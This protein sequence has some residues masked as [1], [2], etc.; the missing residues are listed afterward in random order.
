MFSRTPRSTPATPAWCRATRSRRTTSTSTCRATSTRPRGR[1]HP[2]HRRPPPRRHPHAG[3]RCARRLLAGDPRR[4]RCA[5]TLFKPKPAAPA[6]RASGPG[7]E[8]KAR[9]STATRVRRLHRGSGDPL[10]RVAQAP[11]PPVFGRA[12]GKDCHPKEVIRELAED[13]LATRRAG[14]A[15]RSLRHLPAPDGLLG[16]D[17][18][19]R[20][21]PHRR[22]R[23]GG[24][25]HAH[26]GDR[27]EGQD[28][29]QGL[30]LRP[31]PAKSLIVARYFAEGAGGH[32]GATGQAGSRS[33]ASLAELEEEHGGEEGAISELEKVNRA[34]VVARLKEIKGDK[35]IA[36]DES[37][38]CCGAEVAEACTNDEADLKREVKAAQEA[39]LDQL[40]VRAV[41]EAERG[42]D[43]DPGGGRQVAGHAL[44]PPC[45]ASWIAS[46]RR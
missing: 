1:G 2:G 44:P 11:P 24:Q 12:F 29:G 30:D 3:H 7:D 42:R 15:D 37:S 27:Q 4:A 33:R 43:P 18:A 25:D 35:E 31:R 34:N 41:P 32:R 39:A 16:R 38:P 14:A 21:L 19:G 40:R 28:E 6:T 8:L 23:L 45:R 36:K 17:D 26:P 13:L 10:R 46:R 20:L 5:P 9:P 22:R